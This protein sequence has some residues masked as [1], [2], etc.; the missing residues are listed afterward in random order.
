MGAVPP[1]TANPAGRR[2]SKFHF[3]LCVEYPFLPPDNYTGPRPALGHPSPGRQGSCPW[4]VLCAQGGPKSPSSCCTCYK[5]SGSW[6]SETHT[7]VTSSPAPFCRTQRKP[8]K[9]PDFHNGPLDFGILVNLQTRG[10]G[11]SKFPMFLSLP[12]LLQHT[13]SRSPLSSP[14]DCEILREVNRLG[15]GGCTKSLQGE[16]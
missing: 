3:A 16:E 2:H 14:P 8:W 11:S 4:T 6:V 13:V 1:R 12:S 5:V 9:S 7:G 10:G 15:W